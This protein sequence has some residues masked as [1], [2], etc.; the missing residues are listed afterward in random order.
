MLCLSGFERKSRW[1]PLYS[2]NMSLSNDEFLS[3]FMDS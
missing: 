1:V 3:L 2:V